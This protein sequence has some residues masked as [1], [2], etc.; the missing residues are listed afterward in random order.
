MGRTRATI[1]FRKALGI[2]RMAV[3]P[4]PFN[5]T[6]SFFW[7]LNR[8]EILRGQGCGLHGVVFPFEDEER[9]IE[10]YA[11]F[12]RIVSILFRID[13][14]LGERRRGKEVVNVHQR[15]V[16]R[17]QHNRSHLQLQFSFRRGV[18]RG[19]QFAL[20]IQPVDIVIRRRP[21]FAQSCNRVLIM[22]GA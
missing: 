11:Q 13:H 8:R 12:S 3:C 1:S 10:F 4:P 5:N 9:H 19:E 22:R 17:E 21:H 6:N 7:R 15:I 14:A 20:G 2:V 16:R 18:V